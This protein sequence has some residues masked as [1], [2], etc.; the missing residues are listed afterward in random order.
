M[1]L[2]IMALCSFT[3]FCAALAHAGFLSP[4][5]FPK[6][7]DDLSFIERMAFKSADYDAIVE[8][9]YDKDGNCVSGCA[10]VMPKWEDQLAADERWN[11]LVH[12][13]LIE[14]HGYTENE[15]GSLT[16]PPVEE[17]E[18]P[19]VAFPTSPG[20]SPAPV[21][22]PVATPDPNFQKCAIKNK[23]FENRNIPYR[24]PL[25]YV[26]C[27]TS[28][29]GPRKMNNKTFHG[30]ID[31]RATTGTPVYAPANGVVEWVTTNI[32]GDCGKGLQIKHSGGYA[33]RFCHFSS[34]SVKWG[35]KLSAGCLIGRVGATGSGVTGPHLHY[36]VLK[37]E[38][39][40][41]PYPDYIE[42]EHKCCPG[43]C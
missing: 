6:T 25:G 24:S 35:E 7:I 28:P 10:Y 16:P 17:P 9:V 39:S 14:E 30:G 38:K 18:M 22:P 41:N 21:Q 2:Q 1:R 27:I 33:T 3:I 42:S 11:S 31:F 5:E 40:V 26:A 4:T 13:E 12:E 34:L 8:S 37:N 15:D 20:Y 43:K 32:N 36:A 29:Y 23:S 19:I